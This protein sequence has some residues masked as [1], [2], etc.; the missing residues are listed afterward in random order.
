MENKIARPFLQWTGGKTQLLNQLKDHLPLI[1]KQSAFTYV[2]P[3]VGSGAMLFWILNTFPNVGKVIINDRNE[4]LINTYRVITRYL[5]KLV[6]VLQN[7]HNEFFALKENDLLRKQY[8]LNKREIY[9][10]RLSDETTH[11]GLFIFLNKT[12]FYGLYRVNSKNQFNTTINL[13][14]MNPICNRE[15]IM[16][17]SKAL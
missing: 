4:D 12:C 7:F 14:R 11:A 9:N 16:T 17:V 13:S 2:E 1:T 8:Y 5:E 10:N 15:V 3:F 6:A